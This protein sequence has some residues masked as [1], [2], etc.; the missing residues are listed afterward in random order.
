VNFTDISVAA[1]VRVHQH[2]P[3]PDVKPASLLKRD[4]TPEVEVKGLH[5]LEG[6]PALALP[7]QCRLLLVEYACAL[8]T[9]DHVPTLRL[10]VAPVP[11]PMLRVEFFFH[12]IKELRL[13]RLPA[14]G[15]NCARFT[16]E[17]ARGQGWTGVNWLV[18]D[19]SSDAFAFYAE[20]AEI[21]AV[22]REG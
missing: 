20:Q 10:R 11:E 5:L 6:N 9:L 1:A 18:G 17:D 2:L 21:I 8:A 3:M 7:M 4:R 14:E 15:A 12:G 16:I 13:P 22:T 19:E